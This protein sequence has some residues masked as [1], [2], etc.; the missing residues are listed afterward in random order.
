MRGD[1]YLLPKA[2]ADA[3]TCNLVTIGVKALHQGVVSPLMTHI[4]RGRDGTPVG[5]FPAWME[6]V[7]VKPLVEVIDTVV[8]GE[9]HQLR[10]LGWGQVLGQLCT[11]TPAI[12]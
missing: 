8:E 4:E 11:S 10:G 2:V 1:Y 3:V 9:H 12:N 7:L 5:V 6:D